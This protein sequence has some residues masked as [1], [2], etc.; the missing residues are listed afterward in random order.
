MPKRIVDGDA[1]WTSDKLGQVQPVSFRAEYTNLLPLALGNGVFECEPR[2]IYL[3]V[4][5]YNR[6]DITP[7]IV[8]SI[9]DEFERVK[10]LFRWQDA[11]KLWGFWIGIDQPG[12]LPAPSRTK[13]EKQGPDVPRD[14]LSAFLLENDGYSMA[15]HRLTDG[16]IGIGVGI[17]I[18]GGGETDA[19]ASAAACLSSPLP[20]S[21]EEKTEEQTH[22]LDARSSAGEQKHDPASEKSKQ[23]P[24][25]DKGVVTLQEYSVRQK[26]PIPASSKTKPAAAKHSIPAGWEPP[27]VSDADFD[28]LDF[29]F[30]RTE[31][32]GGLSPGELQRVIYYHWRVDPKRFWPT[33]GRITSAARLEEKLA[34]MVEQVPA[35]YRITGA[36][37]ENFLI[38]DASCT[39]CAGVGHTLQASKR[40][41]AH[42][43]FTE[44]VP[45]TCNRIHP[46][47]WRLA[48]EGAEQAKVAA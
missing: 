3:K 12:R 41:P 32:F 34:T 11:G 2:K 13:H 44:S 8:A 17:G 48:H 21:A 36:A 9:L 7:D 20:P 45:C 30:T 4:Y 33:R 37:Y 47:P 38:P 27:R 16:C 10:L 46:A 31:A 42:F 22:S 19:N 6:P 14:E 18:A 5:G 35:D 43:G 25:R 1:I 26:K 29:A 28:A 15:S 40:Y 24:V 39:L 23:Q